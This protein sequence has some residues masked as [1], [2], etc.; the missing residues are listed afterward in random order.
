MLADRSNPQTP[1]IV[2][3]HFAVVGHNPAGNFFWK[4]LLT[5]TPDTIR[6]TK[7][8]TDPNRPTYDCKQGR[9]MSHKQKEQNPYVIT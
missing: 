1:Y 3:T 5:H 7:Q 2:T 4:L 6:P 8:G 9:V